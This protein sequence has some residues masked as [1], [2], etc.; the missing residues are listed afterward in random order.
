MNTT[1]SDAHMVK[2]TTFV[3][4]KQNIFDFIEYVKTN[5]INFKSNTKRI[6]DL[7]R[8][9]IT[10]N[11]TPILNEIIKLGGT[12]S[13]FFK[14]D[15]L[16]GNN[17]ENLA[18]IAV[19]NSNLYML[20]F[21]RINGVSMIDIDKNNNNLIHHILLND[22][23]NNTANII[24]YLLNLEQ[25]ISLNNKNIKGQTPLD[26]INDKLLR[27]PLNNKYLSLRTKL[28][29]HMY[30]NKYQDECYLKYLDNAIKD[31]AL[32]FKSNNI[33]EFPDNKITVSNC[34]KIEMKAY[35][36]T[37]LNN[38]DKFK[39]QDTYKY[40]VHEL[41]PYFNYETDSVEKE[42][43][44]DFYKRII[45]KIKNT[46]FNTQNQN[47]SFFGI[48]DTTYSI[49]NKPRNKPRNKPHNKPRNQPHNKPHNKIKEH[50]LIGKLGD[51]NDYFL[52]PKNN[53]L[54]Y[55]YNKLKDPIHYISNFIFSENE[56]I[57][58]E[59]EEE[60]EVDTEEQDVDTEDKDVDT[61]D[62][63]VV[64]ED[65]DVDTEDKDVEKFKIVPDTIEGF[66]D[67]IFNARLNQNKFSNDNHIINIKNKRRLI[68]VTIVILSLT[69]LLNYKYKK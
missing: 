58:I 11:N 18:F 47:Q 35:Y 42:T 41:G 68:L 27:D 20:H 34:N 23:T 40:K 66:Y 12:Q 57:L 39:V 56:D 16:S 54:Y 28:K 30:K 7:I 10:H 13:L 45:K 3:K 32:F 48:N 1:I 26:I 37:I 4:Q 43:M 22:N 2:L 62:K 49:D 8:L 46:T 36:K 65:K 67:S 25:T 51:N 6:H 15:T 59:D 19:T 9:I 5:N 38:T 14:N 24:D 17:T 31:P 61:E 60:Q 33:N 21:L 55:I 53:K 50:L 64:T 63:D 52:I 29:L 69:L 44:H